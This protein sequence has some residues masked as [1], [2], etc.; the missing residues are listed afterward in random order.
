MKTK[1]TSQKHQGDIRGFIQFSRAWYGPSNL[2]VI[3]ESNPNFVDDVMFGFYST[4]GGTSGEMKIDWSKLAGEI[5]PQLQ[6]FN[7]G[8]HALNEF[9]DVLSKLAEVYDR[10]ITPEQF[11]AI[12]T[13]CG[14]KDLTKEKSSHDA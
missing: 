6:I 11:C 1:P 10:N 5:V 13:E 8:W 12:L 7:D 3:R 2:K 9:T 4:D 14:F